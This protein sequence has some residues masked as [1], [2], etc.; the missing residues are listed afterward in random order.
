MKEKE[1]EFRR[2][3]EQIQ[4]QQELL[5]QQQEKL[6]A[7]RDEEKKRIDE[8]K[9]LEEER[10]MEEERIR[11]KHEN[12]RREI[13]QAEAI[14]VRVVRGYTS[15]ITYHYS[16]QKRNASQKSNVKEGKK[17]KPNDELR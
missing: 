7:A 10:I 8:I 6:E 2:Q 16:E 3:Q 1:A 15:T 17:R 13:E 9:K 11:I 14:K 12:A 4:Q 5:R